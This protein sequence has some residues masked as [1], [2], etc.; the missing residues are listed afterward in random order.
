MPSRPPPPARTFTDPE[1]VS[2]TV[3]EVRTPKLTPSLERL[4]GAERR[5]GGWL[6]FA[7]EDGRKRRLTTYTPD[8]GT[9]TDFELER[10][11]MRAVPV[12]P[13]PNR[14]ATDR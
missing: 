9:C 1:G 12:P 10:W 7:A 14:R 4:L 13:A 2:W 3:L 5:R 11:R 8:W 6:V